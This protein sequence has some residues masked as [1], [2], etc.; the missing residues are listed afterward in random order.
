[1]QKHGV[2]KIFFAGTSLTDMV[3][4]VH[5]RYGKAHKHIG[6]SGA[7]ADMQLARKLTEIEDSFAKGKRP[8]EIGDE[9]KPVEHA[10]HWFHRARRRG[11][12]DAHR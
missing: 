3:D 5:K 7:T 1:M 12:D 2:D 10:R 8:R 9:E 6:R 11:Q 4:F